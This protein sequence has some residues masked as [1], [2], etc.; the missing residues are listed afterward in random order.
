MGKLSWVNA[1]DSSDLVKG[2][3]NMKEVLRLNKVL[4]LKRMTV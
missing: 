3:D 1:E 2:V 4:R